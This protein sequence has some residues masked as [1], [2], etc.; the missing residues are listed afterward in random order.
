MLD[1]LKPGLATLYLV[2]GYSI[3]LGAVT[4]Y[5]G[6][7]QLGILD[8]ES[9]LEFAERSLG[10]GFR[11]IDQAQF[12]TEALNKRLQWFRKGRH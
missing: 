11:L 2:G 7:V 6:L 8:R 9:S 12:R 10:L 3:A 5:E 1:Y 4:G